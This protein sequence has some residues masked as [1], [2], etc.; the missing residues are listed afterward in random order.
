MTADSSYLYVA[1]GEAGLTV[2]DLSN[3]PEMSITGRWDGAPPSDDYSFAVHKFHNDTLNRAYLANGDG[4]LKVID[5]TDPSSPAFIMDGF[6]AHNCEDVYGF[7]RAD[8]QFLLIA[9]RDWGVAVVQVGSDG[10]LMQRGGWIAVPG[11]TR[12][13]FYA[14][15][16]LFVANGQDGVQ[17]FDLSNIDNPRKIAE[18]NT[19][20]NSRKVFA[21]L[22]MVYVADWH[23]GLVILKLEGDSLKLVAQKNVDGVAK[24]VLVNDGF[25]FV[26][27][28][29]GGLEIFDVSDPSEPQLI[30]QIDDIGNAL[31]LEKAGDYILAGTRNG[32][33][34]ISHTE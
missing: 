11:Y 10:N 8:T 17:V 22:P 23:N 34:V 19:A 16:L 31:S 5:V 14:D 29:N 27:S 15:S 26:A 32:V 2:I 20:G 12:G 25:C 21:Q 24:D 13:V 18:F 6:W 1:S 7:V 33:Y 28:G 4:N 9:R 3:L 30:Q